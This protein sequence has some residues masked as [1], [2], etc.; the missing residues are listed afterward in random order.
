MKNCVLMIC[1][2][3][4]A[5]MTKVAILSILEHNPTRNFDILLYIDGDT[6]QFECIKDQVIVKQIPFLMPILYDVGGKN[7]TVKN[8]EI[9]SY[10]IYL[11]DKL[12]YE[13]DNI[14]LL[15]TDILCV[16][17]FNSVFENVD[18]VLGFNDWKQH[19]AFLDKQKIRLW[20]DSKEVYFN[21]CFTVYPSFLLKQ[22]N[23]FAEYMQ[24]LYIRSNIYV[25][26]EQDFLNYIFKDNKRCLPR[27][28]NYMVNNEEKNTDNTIVYHYFH[29]TKPYSCN[30]ILMVVNYKIFIDYYNSILKYKNFISLD[31]FNKC[32]TNLKPLKDFIEKNN[33]TNFYNPIM[34]N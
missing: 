11:M 33:I 24:E 20:Y 9:I 17:D 1:D 15:D 34:E 14:L 5:D 28:V 10:R 32:E 4:Y 19:K 31:Y 22:H 6:N 3:S 7:L 16:N 25:C 29:V 21:A 30:F 18:A 8:K 2:N 13:Y 27:T 12:K 26:P 23:L